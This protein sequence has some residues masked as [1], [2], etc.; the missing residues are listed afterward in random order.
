MG[1]VSSMAADE[2][3]SLSHLLLDV[4]KLVAERIADIA[5]RTTD[6]SSVL[7]VAE[8]SVDGAG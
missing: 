4:V 3:L 6:D 2:V 7:R 8:M 1:E 5:E